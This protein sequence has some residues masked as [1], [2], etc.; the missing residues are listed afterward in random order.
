M[1]TDA[2]NLVTTARTIHLPEHKETIHMISMLRKEACSRSIHDLA[3]IPTQN[4]L[5]D[6]LT[7]ASAK[8]D[9]LITAVKTGRLFDVEIHVNFGTL[10]EQNG[11]L[12]YM[13]QDIY[14]HKG[15]GCFLPK[16]LEGFS[17]RLHKKHHSMWWLWRLTI[18]KNRK[19]QKVCDW[20]HLSLGVTVPAKPALKSD[21]D[22]ELTQPRFST[23]MKNVWAWRTE[24]YENNVYSRR[25]VHSLSLASDVDFGE[26]IVS[27]LGPYDNFS[28]SVSLFF[29]SQPCD[30]VVIKTD[31][32]WQ[33]EQMEK[34]IL[35]SAL[36][37]T[38]TKLWRSPAQHRSWCLMRRKCNQK[39]S[40]KRPKMLVL[41][42]VPWE[43]VNGTKNQL[44]DQ[45]TW[46]SLMPKVKKSMSPICHFSENSGETTT[47]MWFWQR[48]LTAYRRTQG[49]YL[50]TMAWR[51]ATQVQAMICQSTQ[52]LTPQGMF[53]SCG[54][55]VKKTTCSDLWSEI[56]QKEAE[57]AITDSR[58]R[59]A[60]MLF[61]DLE[62]VALASEGSDLNTTE[63]HF[64]C[65]QPNAFK[66]PQRG[67]W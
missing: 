39:N 22:L 57:G 59:T 46:T 49:S 42:K 40:Q 36:K 37:T 43:W 34:E 44:G 16:C 65:L 4:W 11:F 66:T 24:C 6:C 48:R 60:D 15:K 18:L 2:K 38:T 27:V 3:H 62:S 17:Y 25:L 19:N 35:L 41:I 23:Q 33:S 28:F 63:D 32:C 26:N 58:E 7:K 30:H 61:N 14:A 55:Q 64:L 53:D 54:N 45:R 52:E 67:T 29:F 9:N 31:W 50:K 5:A 51:D 20:N 13:V 47:R 8:A 10:M 21:R 12:I 1:R 56:W